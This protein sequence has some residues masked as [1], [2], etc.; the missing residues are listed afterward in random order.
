MKNK[1]SKI[2]IKLDQEVQN[3]FI[4]NKNNL[5][6]KIASILSVESKN[7]KENIDIKM[8]KIFNMNIEQFMICEM[9]E[10]SDLAEKNGYRKVT[11][12]LNYLSTFSAKKNPD[13]KLRIENIRLHLKNWKAEAKQ[14]LS[15]KEE[16]SLTQESCEQ[17]KNENMSKS[18]EGHPPTSEG[19]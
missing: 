7:E 19:A 4:Q 16:K 18:S 5:Y 17:P 15:Q 8:P 6:D 14:S 9:K 11:S 12:S 2:F 13:I 1:L 10:F 3:E